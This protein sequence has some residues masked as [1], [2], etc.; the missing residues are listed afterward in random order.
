MANATLIEKAR[1][2]YG[3]VNAD[4][5]QESQIKAE[6]AAIDSQRATDDHYVAPKKRHSPAPAPQA[7]AQKTRRRVSLRRRK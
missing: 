7:K 6:M 1:S 5:M 4:Q 3:I 2:E